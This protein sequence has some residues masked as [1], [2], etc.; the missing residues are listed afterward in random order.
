MYAS[1]RAKCEVHRKAYRGRI[2]RAEETEGEDKGEGEK[3][4]GGGE[5]AKRLIDV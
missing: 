3:E 5:C 1:K 4:R 2:S